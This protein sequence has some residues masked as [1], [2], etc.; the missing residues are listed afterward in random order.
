MNGLT[1]TELLKSESEKSEYLARL[2]EAGI[3][4]ANMRDAVGLPP[5]QTFYG[6]SQCGRPW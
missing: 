3:E 1:L 6:C 5:R 4:D 2:I